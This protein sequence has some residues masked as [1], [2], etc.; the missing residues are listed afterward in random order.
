MCAKSIY[1][2]FYLPNTKMIGVLYWHPYIQKCFNF[3]LLNEN[4]IF[5]ELLEIDY[6]CIGSIEKHLIY[7]SC[8]NYKY[9][10]L[11]K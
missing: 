10:S 1:I 11:F 3:K 7:Y 8:I 5:N 4:T 2:I 6:R 9:I